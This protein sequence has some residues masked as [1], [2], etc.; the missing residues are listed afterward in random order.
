MYSVNIQNECTSIHIYSAHGYTHWYTHWRYTH[1]YTHWSTHTLSGDSAHWYIVRIDILSTL[2]TYE[3]MSSSHLFDMQS[4]RVHF[5]YIHS[6]PNILEDTYIRNS[7]LYMYTLRIQDMRKHLSHIQ[8]TS[9]HFVYIHS[10]TI[11]LCIHIYAKCTFIY[12]LCVLKTCD[13]IPSSQL[14]HLQRRGG[15]MGSRP[16]KMYGERLGDGVEYHLMSPTP[17]RLVPFT[18][19]R[20]A[21]WISWK[22]YSTPAPHLSCRVYLCILYTYIQKRLFLDAYTQMHIYTCRQC[23]LKTCESVA[24]SHLFHMQGIGVHLVYTSIQQRFV[25]LIHLFSKRALFV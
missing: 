20:R 23:I 18:T 16:K 8:S 4:V 2:E 1:W 3:S 7:H 9:V 6:N 21:H 12:I 5:V 25:G 13:S 24:S 11:V 14:F 10:T 17:R 19:G 15:G 22:W